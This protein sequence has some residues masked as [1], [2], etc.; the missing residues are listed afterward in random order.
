MFLLQHLLQ[1]VVTVNCGF[2]SWT[3]P[4][5]SDARSLKDASFLVVLF[6]LWSALSNMGQ[7]H[8]YLDITSCQIP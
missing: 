1:C 8:N 4:D 7:I 3:I 6:L 5:N 2:S